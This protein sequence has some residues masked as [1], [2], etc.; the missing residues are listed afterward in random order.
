MELIITGA[1][2]ILVGL[3]YYIVGFFIHQAKNKLKATFPPK[4]IKDMLEFKDSLNVEQW[5][6][7]EKLRKE[8]QIT[9]ELF[10]V[11]VISSM[12]Y[13]KIILGKKYN[14]LRKMYP[15]KDQTE[16]LSSLLYHHLKA[17][18]ELS[19]D[20]QEFNNMFEKLKVHTVTPHELFTHVGSY[21]WSK[22]HELYSA[23]VMQEIDKIIW[24]NSGDN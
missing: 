6:K 18:P 3:G 11:F 24:E 2:I 10:P 14:F 12:N 15:D 1:L 5:S 13:T 17:Q 9:D 4:W 16:L 21:M 7:L 20:E 22:N 19:D 23:A 8:F